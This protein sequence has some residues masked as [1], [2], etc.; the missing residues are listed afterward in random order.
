M[1]LRARH[2]S[3]KAIRRGAIL[4]AAESLLEI[5]TSELPPAS[6]I[7]RQANLAKGTLYLYFD[8]KEEIY[9]SLLMRGFSQWMDA[10]TEALSGIERSLPSFISRYTEFCLANPTTLYLASMSPTLIER[11]I[12][13]ASAYAFKKGLADSTRYIGMLISSAFPAVSEA[14]G[15]ALL[16]HTISLT[17]GLWQHAH[18]VEVIAKVYH[19]EELTILRLDF[20]HELRQAIEALWK[21]T[22][23]AGSRLA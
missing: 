19:R 2:D 8:T 20:E 4:K 12:G 17:T 7:A 10:I 15:R 14:Q 22:F 13:E 9:F 6:A 1:L 23:T 5:G 16:L 21:G 18:P 3:D 11:N